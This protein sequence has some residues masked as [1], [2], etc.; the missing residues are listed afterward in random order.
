[1]KRRVALL[2]ITALVISLAAFQVSAEQEENV[3]YLDD[4]YHYVESISGS[5]ET[6]DGT[7]TYNF[8]SDVEGVVV[9]NV[10]PVEGEDSYNYVREAEY[11]GETQNV[12]IQYTYVATEN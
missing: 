1:M 11:K 6:L 9:K 7:E 8:G 2:L 3:I 12:Y 4:G 5:K 10:T